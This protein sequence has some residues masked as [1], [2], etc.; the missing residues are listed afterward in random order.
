MGHILIVED[1]K[2]IQELLSSFLINAGHEIT[3]A[4]DGLESI[5]IFTSGNYDLILLDIMLPKLDGYGVCEY[6][7]NTSGI[8]IIM[9][10]A[11]DSEHD[12]IKGFDYKIDDYIAKPF[13]IHILLRKIEAILRRISSQPAEHKKTIY[14]S[15]VVDSDNC[16]VKVNSKSILLTPREFGILTTLLENKGKVLSRGQLLNSLWKYDF[17]GDERVVDTHVKNLRKKLGVDYIETMR[18]FGYRIDHENQK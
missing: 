10:T 3:V 17:Y 2:D 12:Q 6:I 4:G 5:A 16:T 9:L 15:M 1:D 11:L 7:R 18:G 8:P 13:S 14:K